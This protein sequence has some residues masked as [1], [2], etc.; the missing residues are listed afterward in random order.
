MAQCS[1]CEEYFHRQ[2]QRIPD[3]VYFRINKDKDWYCLS[4]AR[5]IENWSGTTYWLRLDLINLQCWKIEDHFEH[6]NIVYTLYFS[7]Q[8]LE[9]K[10]VHH[11]TF[12][13]LGTE[14]LRLNIYGNLSK[15]YTFYLKFWQIITYC[16]F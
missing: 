14:I 6:T 9:T 7:Y 12:F 8:K 5:Q 2:C 1:R 11:W 3:E 10:I 4:C 16:S 15:K 13:S